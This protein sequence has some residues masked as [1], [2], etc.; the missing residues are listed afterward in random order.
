MPMELVTQ[1]PYSHPYRWD[2]TLFGGPKLWR[3]NALAGSL[4][5]WLDAEDSSTIT[6]NGSTVSQ[7][8]DKSGNGR[9][10][11]RAAATNQP[12]YTTS[13]L[14]G[15]PVLTFDGTNDS[16]QVDLTFLA[17]TSYSVSAVFARS[18]AANANYF[19][20]GGDGAT[21]QQLVVG[22]AANTTFLYAQYNNDLA[23]SVPAYTAP[24]PLLLT[25]SLDTDVGRS[26]Y[27]DGSL[28][29]SN[30]NKTPLITNTGGLLG[31]WSG[32][33]VGYAG[34]L[35]ELVFTNNALSSGNRQKLE[36][37]LAWKWGTQASLPADH[38]YKS[39]PPTA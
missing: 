2:G 31:S 15:K 16:M 13:G 12:T 9:N 38:P 6:L 37:Y 27:S 18:S 24:T 36:G 32:A 3:P 8:S 35:A 30:T 1:L 23:A 28:L 11:V 34:Y 22:W 14:N 19:I 4:A 5:L 17:G 25:L 26:M 7:W 10:A 21:N 33:A 29:V 39:F 20:G